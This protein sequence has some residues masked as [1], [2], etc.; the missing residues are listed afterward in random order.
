MKNELDIISVSW[1]QWSWKEAGQVHKEKECK[2]IKVSIIRHSKCSKMFALGSQ[3]G[4]A[5]TGM[6]VGIR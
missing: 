6:A 5:V 3:E 4:E 1:N 2:K